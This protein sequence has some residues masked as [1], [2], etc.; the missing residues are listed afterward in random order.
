MHS[1]GVGKSCSPTPQ[2]TSSRRSWPTS[3]GTRPTRSST[4]TACARS[5]TGS[6]A[7]ATPPRSR[8]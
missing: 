8:R 7:T 3:P 2:T 4:R 5:S 1:T 6:A